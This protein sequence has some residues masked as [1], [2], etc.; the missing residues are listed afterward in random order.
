MNVKVKVLGR[1][2]PPQMN[3][4]ELLGGGPI[5]RSSRYSQCVGVAG[6]T[7]LAKILSTKESETGV[8]LG[9]TANCCA[10]PGERGRTQRKRSATRIRGMRRGVCHKRQYDHGQKGNQRHQHPK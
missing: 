3:V 5:S 8:I 1:N 2:R 6:H 9:A 7:F 4:R 10:F